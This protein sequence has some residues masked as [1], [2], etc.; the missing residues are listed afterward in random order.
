MSR[1]ADM[2]EGHTLQL[3]PTPSRPG[4][5][6]EASQ[7]SDAS[8]SFSSC[9]EGQFDSPQHSTEAGKANDGCP[10]GK[11]VQN[12]LRRQMLVTAGGKGGAAIAAAGRV[13][14]ETAFGHFPH[15]HRVSDDFNFA[16]WTA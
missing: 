11:N 14:P 10:E 5:K 4:S 3:F 8:E 9:D 1:F 2:Q 7:Y 6:F 15:H 13:L 16:L 12:Q